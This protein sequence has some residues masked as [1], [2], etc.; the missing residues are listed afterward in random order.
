MI[1]RIAEYTEADL[2]AADLRTQNGL[3]AHDLTSEDRQRLESDADQIK[4]E[5]ARRIRAKS[6][7]SMRLEEAAEAA[8]GLDMLE[9]GVAQERARRDEAIRAAVAGGISAYRVAQYLGISQM[10][11]GRIVKAG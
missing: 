1:P 9:D 11:V 2:Q 6:E 8:R 5:Q 7:A 3:A 10:Q 4:A